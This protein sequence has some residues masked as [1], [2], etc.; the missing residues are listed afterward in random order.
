M[1]KKIYANINLGP[2]TP[3]FRFK[4]VII[5]TNWLFQGILYADKTEK[6]FKILLDGVLATVLC[7]FLIPSSN[8]Y[9]GL[10]ISLIVSHTVLF[11][12]N[13]QL[14]ALAKNFNI[15]YNEPQRIIDYAYGLKERT[16]KE[17][18]INCLVVY[19][20][21]VRGEIKPTSDLDVRVIRKSGIINGFR[22]CIFGLKERSRALLHRF[23]LDMYVI[24]DP[25]HLLK[26]R[27]D[28]IPKILYDPYNI[29]GPRKDALL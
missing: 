5:L 14:F 7:F 25:N 1:T 20:S 12:F 27:Q 21:L 23:P 16:S 13:G 15:V 29:L 8:A 19:G 6:A 26:M 24:D 28:E 18:S 10:I 9:S 3:I 11:I 22:A 17:R 2:L 4:V